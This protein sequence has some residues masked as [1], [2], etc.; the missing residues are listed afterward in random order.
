MDTTKSLNFT[1]S[2]E[3]EDGQKTTLTVLRPC[4]LDLFVNARRLRVTNH[5]SKSDWMYCN[6]GAATTGL[7][8]CGSHMSL[9]T[10]DTALSGTDG[11][12]QYRDVIFLAEGLCSF[13]DLLGSH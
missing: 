3:I 8:G 9:V 5:A 6:V 11:E 4:E 1:P 13:G 7:F 2:S 10:A 12:R